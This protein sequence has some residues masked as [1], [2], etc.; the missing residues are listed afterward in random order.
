MFTDHTAFFLYAESSVHVG[1]GQS[2]GTVDLAIQRESYTQYPVVPASGL[3]GA[4]RHWFATT[5]RDATGEAAEASSTDAADTEAADTEATHTAVFGP[6]TANAGDHAGAVAVSDARLLLFPMRSM[7]GVFAWVTCPALLHRYKRDMASIDAAPSWSVPSMPTQE[8]TLLAAPSTPLASTGK[9]MLDEYVFYNRE[10]AAVAT[11]GADLAATAL[12]QGDSYAYWRERLETNLVIVD[13]ETFR[14]FTLHSTEVQARIKIDDETG[15]TSGPT[16]NLFYQENLPPE[17]LFYAMAFAHDDL[18]GQL[19]D[20]GGAADL[21]DY[22]RS[23]DGHRLQIGGDATI[24]KGI[25]SVHF[26]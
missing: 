7:R 13:D 10:E 4:L 1:S 8:N 26:L 23:L 18:S 9:V 16:G 14:D 25:T 12:P 3:K 17:S 20:A 15:T 22:L 6:D 11:I 21:L 24:G 2:L 19:G 5:G